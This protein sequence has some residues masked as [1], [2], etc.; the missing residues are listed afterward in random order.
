MITLWKG[1]K[2]RVRL[3]FIGSRA[4]GDARKR[5]GFHYKTE[6]CDEGDE[7]RSFKERV[8]GISGDVDTRPASVVA[9]EEPGF[10]SYAEAAERQGISISD[11][12]V[13]KIRGSGTP[14]KFSGMGGMTTRAS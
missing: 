11:A 13:D 2:A 14:G 7:S 4:S 6:V 10:V 3:K 1:V 8:L 5:V 12:E 9:A